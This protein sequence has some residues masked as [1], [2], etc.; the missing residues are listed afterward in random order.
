MKKDSKNIQIFYGP[1]A[2]LIEGIIMQPIDTLKNLKQCNQNIKFNNIRITQ[3]YKGFIPYTTQMTFKY[4]LRFNTFYHLKSKNDNYFQ[5]FLAG[6][7]AG[8]I[9]SLFITP[10]ELVKTHLQTTNNKYISGVLKE[11]IAKNGINGLYRGFTPTS[12]RQSINQSFNFSVYFK[13]KNTFIDKNEKPDI[14]KIM[15]IS[16][17][18]S[19]IGPLI[20]N[21]FDVIKTRYQNPKYNYTNVLKSINEIIKNEGFFALWK[22]IELRLLRVCGGQI[23][24]FY[25]IENISFYL[26]D[27]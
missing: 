6:I 13:L 3:L 18:S 26:K 7:S 25:T 2:G 12:I 24:T 19:S 20:N 4:F 5:N 16:F 14:F 15:G 27:S 9:E 21:P 17:I 23:I 8:V 22:G 1:I 10:F 11:I